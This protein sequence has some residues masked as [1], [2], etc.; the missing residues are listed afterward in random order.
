MQAPRPD[1]NPIPVDAPG[2]EA[3]DEAA[4]PAEVATLTLGEFNE[5]LG[6]DIRVSVATL[7]ALGFKPYDVV[8]NS[9]LY[10]RDMVPQM[11]GELELHIAKVAADFKV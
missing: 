6:L 9:R 5:L 11:L 8:R 2:I 1:C 7:H 4:A 3:D 10:R